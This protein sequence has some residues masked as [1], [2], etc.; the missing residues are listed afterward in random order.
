MLL[1]KADEKVGCGALSR[2]FAEARELAGLKIE[3]GKTPPSFHEQRS[4]AERLYR[5]QGINTQ[6]LLGHASQEMTDKYNNDRSNQ[7]IIL[8]V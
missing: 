5:K 4:L 1:E 8:A 7:W 3:A 2:E 6:L